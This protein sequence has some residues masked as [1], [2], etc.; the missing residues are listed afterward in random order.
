MKQSGSD[1]VSAGIDELVSRLRQD[2][3]EAGETE[4]EAI[5][6][7]ARQQAAAL[8]ADARQQ[9]D[10]LIAEAK[11][12]ARRE[13]QAASEAMQIAFR[14]L[15]LDMKSMLEQ[16]FSADVSRLVR[17]QLDQPQLLAK[18][19]RAAAGRLLE[20]AELPA[21]SELDLLLPPQILALDDI[22]RSPESAMQGP[23]ADLAFALQIDMLRDGVTLAAGSAD[24][25]GI[26]LVLRDEKIEVDL[27]DR[28][29]AGLLLGYLQP[30]FRAILDG[31][32]R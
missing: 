4:A 25:H 30:R 10:K 24:H 22:R 2:G 12:D 13:Q 32:I 15:V 18:L 26:T 1:V 17:Q 8:L 20:Q 3:V 19:I 7:D 29:I 23:L 11:E 28:A 27:S 16:R 31:I 14:D 6:A 5:L 21:E 9:A